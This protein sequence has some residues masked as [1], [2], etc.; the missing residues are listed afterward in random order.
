MC[1]GKKSTVMLYIMCSRCRAVGNRNVIC[2]STTTAPI[3]KKK[4][5]KIII[6]NKTQARTRPNIRTFSRGYT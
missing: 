3:M 1:V 2:I 5:H 4:P 6:K